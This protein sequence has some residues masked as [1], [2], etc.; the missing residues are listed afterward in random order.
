L[1]AKAVDAR[2]GKFNCKRDSVKF[3]ADTG[4]VLKGTA[5]AGID[6]MV[7]DGVL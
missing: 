5:S 7:L 2:C 3:L 6:Q 1:D 4:D